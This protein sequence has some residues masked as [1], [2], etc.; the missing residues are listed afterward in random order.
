[1]KD[2]SSVDIMNEI[3][4]FADEQRSSRILLLVVASHGN[5]K[6]DILCSDGSV[7]NKKEILD[8]LNVNAHQ[9]KVSCQLLAFCSAMLMPEDTELN[10]TGYI[11]HGC[12]LVGGVLTVL[13]RK[14]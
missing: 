5:E 11:L 4:Q 14:F 1:M 6:D 2:L 3:R 10:S 13:Q 9:P 12:V 7:C 8:A